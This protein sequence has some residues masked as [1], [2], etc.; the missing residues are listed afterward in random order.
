LVGRNLARERRDSLLRTA[1]IAALG[2]GAI[3]LIGAW[4]WSYLG[5]RERSLGTEQALAAWAE[6]AQPYAREQLSQADDDYVALFPILDDLSGIRRG[7]QQPDPLPLRFGLSQRTTTEARVNAAYR[8][9][10]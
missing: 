10:L 2:I 7:L 4:T 6:E 8:R 1:G 9:A 5:N 3:L